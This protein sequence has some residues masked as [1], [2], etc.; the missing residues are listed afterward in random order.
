VQ[1]IPLHVP[2]D[3]HVGWFGFVMSAAHE[4]FVPGEPGT[5]GKKQVPPLPEL[6][7]ALTRPESNERLATAMAPTMDFLMNER[8]VVEER[9]DFERFV[10]I[11]VS[12]LAG[13]SDRPI[14]VVAFSRV[15]AVRGRFV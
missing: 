8:R 14:R 15:G 12:T 7:S 10:F 4:H 3:G 9:G 6:S 5:S 13:L 2:Q 1:L 11:G